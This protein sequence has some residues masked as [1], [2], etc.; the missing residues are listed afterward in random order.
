MRKCVR[1][2]FSE[3]KVDETVLFDRHVFRCLIINT[4]PC[5]CTFSLPWI[6]RLDV[7]LSCDNAIL[8]IHMQAI[9]FSVNVGWKKIIKRDCRIEIKLKRVIIDL[10]QKWRTIL[11]IWKKSDWMWN[12]RVNNTSAPFFPD[13]NLLL[14]VI[15]L[16]T[17]VSEIWKMI[18]ECKKN[19]NTHFIS[20]S[21]LYKWLCAI[22]ISFVFHLLLL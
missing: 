4:G 5:V 14:A 9:A 18:N 8:H 19:M 6:W 21:I 3:R 15:I 12:T 2:L 20:L 13:E 1:R 7:I 11:Q 10:C 22:R 17:Y 16:C